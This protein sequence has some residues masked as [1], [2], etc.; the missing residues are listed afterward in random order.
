MQAGDIN[1]YYG[2]GILTLSVAYSLKFPYS[3]KMWKESTQTRKD[4]NDQ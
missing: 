2:V 3:S 1:Q 4:Y